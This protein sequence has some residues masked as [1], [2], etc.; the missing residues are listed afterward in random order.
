M[1]VNDLLNEYL[2]A[3]DAKENE[4]IEE[5]IIERRVELSKMHRDDVVEYLLMTHGFFMPMPEVQE[6]A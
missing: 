1:K 4:R 6:G 2:T 5:E 3:V